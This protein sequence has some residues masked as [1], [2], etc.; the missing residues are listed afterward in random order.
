MSQRNERPTQFE[1]N[2][3]TQLLIHYAAHLTPKCLSSRLEEEWLADSASRFSARSRLRFALG[4]FWAAMVIVNEFPRSD[5][6]VV[7]PVAARGS[8]THSDRNF[9]YVSLPSSTLFLILGIYTALFGG[10]ITTLAHTS[11]VSTPVKL[12]GQQQDSSML[13]RR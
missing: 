11:E 5:V 10:L 12:Q 8:I 4:C 9:G 3:V 13:H 7:S 2:S 6:E 1:L